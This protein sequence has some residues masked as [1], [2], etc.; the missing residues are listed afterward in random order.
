MRDVYLVI[1][2]VIAVG[3]LSLSIVSLLKQ[4]YRNSINRLF[5][6]FSVLV[7]LWILSNNISN[8]IEMPNNVAL[9]A[10]YIV[11]SSSLGSA[12]LLMQFIMKF[13]NAR[14]LELIAGRALLPLWAVC[15][16]CFTPFVVEGVVAQDDVYAVTFGPL[17][18]LY[19]LG[20]FFASGLVG[21]GMFY[22]LRHSRGTKRRQLAAISTG[23]GFSLPLV[24]LLDFI[25]PLTTGIFSVTEFGITP[26]IILVISLY[27]G[28]VRYSLFDI[29]LAAIRTVAY[30]LSLLTLSATYYGLAYI[31]S[32]TLFSGNF[33]SSVSVSPVSIA[34]AL[35]LAF[36]FQPIK[37]FFDKVTNKIFYK[38]NYNSD[39]F[40]ARLNR[41]LTQ[42]TDLRDML[43]RIAYEIGHTLKSEQAFFFI[44]TFNEHYVSAGTPHH[45]QMPKKD[46]IQLEVAQDND[47][48]LI[49]AS[50]LDN[51]PIR[52]LMLSH[53]I[54][55]ILPLVHKG[56][57]IGHLCLG[58]HLTSGYTN[59][60]MKV[61]STISDELTIAIRNALAVQEIR[62]LNA[63]LQQRI[64]NATQELRATNVTLRRLDKVKDEFVSIASHQLRTPLTS[65]KGYI[66]MVLDGDAGKITDSQRH[67]LD[68]AFMSSERMVHL[69][70]DFLNVSRI[71]TGKF[72][73]DRRP[74]DLSKVVE[75]EIDSLQP[76]A[77]SRNLKFVYHPPKNFP[78]LDIDEGKIRQVV[79][80]FADNSLYYSH[81]NTKINVN[82]SVEGNEV[83]F[84]VKDTGIGVPLSEQAQLFGKFYRASNAKK[85]R[86]DGTGVGLFLAKKVI[87]AHGGTIVFESV[88]GKG[89]TF[90]FRLPIKPLESTSAGDANDLDN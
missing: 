36:I 46:A 39:D 48:S 65:V 79:M 13:A 67:L 15:A 1:D 32:V 16:I 53:R 50:L 61:L 27:Y 35:L 21:Y 69:I 7:A 26:L 29:R 11:F 73:I 23:L 71:Q 44:N 38:D 18:W 31:I 30:I 14:R 85:Q 58:D 76:S 22:G 87:D 41:I 20:L 42:T 3:L 55:I 45:K 19:A 47:H 77:I 10:D 33:S 6:T 84:T 12:I 63:S 60:D 51:N 8:N 62:E 24:I 72:I 82:L 40:F 5:A 59:R 52:R 49:N 83:L 4:G 54:E 57:Y 78:I 17:I 81:E 43:E 25:I 88:E 66:S 68:E 80:N 28:V 34:L 56:K 90:G 9:F 74:I 86:P 70:N 75:Q 37:R 64:A 2:I 89:S